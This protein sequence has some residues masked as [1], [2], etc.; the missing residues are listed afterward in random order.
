MS[1]STTEYLDESLIIPLDDEI[2][3]EFRLIPAGSFLMGSRGND[4]DE[5]PIHHVQISRSFYLGK[6][7]VTQE[8]FKVWTEQAGIGHKNDFAF[9]PQHPAESMD[10]HQATAYCDWLTIHYGEKFPSGYI[11][12]LPM[13][14]QW[15]YTCRADTE[16]EYYTGDGEAALA[17][18]GW[19]GGNSEGGVHP[20][21]K[22]TGNLWGLY[23]M[24]GNVWEWCQDAWN[25]TTYKRRP[26]GI[27]DPVCFSDEQDVS[28]VIRGGS[29]FG[30]P[31]D[32]RSALRYWGRPFN[33]RRDWGFRVCLSPDPSAH[34][35]TSAAVSELLPAEVQTRQMSKSQTIGGE[36]A[37]VD[38]SQ[39]NLPPRGGRI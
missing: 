35:K 29:W 20:V 3:L 23:D 14:A 37:E 18:A 8:Q 11:A 4:R 32:C 12:G 34:E 27:S 5:E 2:N 36:T 1:P 16:T 15:E 6:F 33:R 10:W 38:L 24:H 25:A 22:K 30:S 7:P 26:N 13:E 19:Y 9:N 17:S 28:R 39:N 21:G 31:D